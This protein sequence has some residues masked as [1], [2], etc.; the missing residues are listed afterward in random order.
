MKVQVIKKDANKTFH[1]L[2]G[3]NR[4]INP[5]Q[6]TKLAES[7]NK[8]GCIRPIVVSTFSFL[9]GG[10][11]TYIIDGQHLF[12]ALGRN[13]MEYPYVS[14]EIKDKKE[15]IEKIALLNASSKNWAMSDYVKAWSNIS[16]DYRV[17]N[18]Y[19]NKYDFE[20]SILATILN[21]SNRTHI[22][23]SLKN[24]SFKIIDIKRNTEI[25][26]NLT[27]V[28]KVINRT[29]RVENRYLCLEYVNFIRTT[30]DY[31]HQNF[32][33]SLVRNQKSLMFVTQEPGK[34]KEFF[35]NLN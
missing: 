13:H 11:K 19:F 30:T 8:M 31:H 7:L 25:L 12:F 32:I 1:L 5:S 18:D 17:L 33:K 6:V 23:K 16:D 20:I 9:P 28:L 21:S 29:S 3:I 35:K 14:I 10:K 24:G 34:L 15:L 26:D 2:E 22:G 4:G 27:D